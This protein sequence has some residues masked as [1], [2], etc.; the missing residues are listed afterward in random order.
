[1]AW[2]NHAIAA[3][4]IGCIIGSLFVAGAEFIARIP[5]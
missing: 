4:L 1:M 2:I 3:I 5:L